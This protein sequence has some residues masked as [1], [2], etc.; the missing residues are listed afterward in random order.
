MPPIMRFFRGTQKV[1]GK[2]KPPLSSR[3]SS[4]PIT[5]RTQKR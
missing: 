2:E 5:P 3:S 4:T 1:K